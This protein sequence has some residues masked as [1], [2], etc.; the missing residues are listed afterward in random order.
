MVL[1]LSNFSVH[2]LRTT[3]VAVV[4]LLILFSYKYH[5]QAKRI[6]GNGSPLK[7]FSVVY[8]DENATLTSSLTICPTP[9]VNE[10]E[11]IDICGLDFDLQYTFSFAWVNECGKSE[12]SA[13]VKVRISDA[14]PGPPALIREST[15]KRSDMLK[16]RWE[17]PL[18]IILL[19]FIIMK[20]I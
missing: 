16:I 3:V 5:T 15:K 8:F 17:K 2:I 4:V 14:I 12:Q 1:S 11:T 20:C 7:E 6:V 13:S 18:I 19:Q 10:K 9:G